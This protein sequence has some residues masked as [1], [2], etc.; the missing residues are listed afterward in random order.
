MTVEHERQ[1]ERTIASV[2]HEIDD[3]KH[4]L[5]DALAVIAR[6]EALAYNPDLGEDYADSAVVVD[7]TL[8]QQA[9]DKPRDLPA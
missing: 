8:L 3:L 6:V 5:A 7:A 4:R 9:L 1:C 2:V